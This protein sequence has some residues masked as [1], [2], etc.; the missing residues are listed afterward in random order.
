MME[1]IQ[2]AKSDRLGKILQHAFDEEAGQPAPTP[3]LRP[4][5][6]VKKDVRLLPEL[7]RQ[8]SQV[9][10]AAVEAIRPVVMGSAP[11]PILFHGPPGGGK[12]CAALCLADISETAWYVTVEE[13]CDSVMGKGRIGAGMLWQRISEKDLIVLDELGCRSGV[14]DLEFSAVKR[15]LDIRETRH[16]RCL[17]AISNVH[18]EALIQLYDRRIYSRLT[19]G[20][21]YQMQSGDRRRDA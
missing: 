17:G 16:H 20:L 10:N 5:S 7:Q 14:G 18:P 6:I 9:D 4:L 19:C 3:G 12:T 2:E 11:W 13:L 21:V 1:T 15:V 8:W